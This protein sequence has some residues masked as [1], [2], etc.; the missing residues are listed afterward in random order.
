MQK[1]PKGA[2]KVLSGLK[3][4]DWQETI[5]FVVDSQKHC[6]KKEKKESD[7]RNINSS[8]NSNIK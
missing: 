3:N 7:D 6:E 5:T 1:M 2:K 4:T 8:N